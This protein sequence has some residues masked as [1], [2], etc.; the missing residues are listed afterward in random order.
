M[1]EN[2]S[3]MSAEE[4]N[5]YRKWL[6]GR[7]LGLGDVSE[8]RRNEESENEMA[9]NQSNESWKLEIQPESWLKA[10]IEKEAV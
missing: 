6:G 5:K 1:T 2:R 7:R 4:E 9:W 8:T 10:K 3:K